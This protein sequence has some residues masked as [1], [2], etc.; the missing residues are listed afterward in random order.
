[1]NAVLSTRN[2]AQL[3]ATF[4]A[5]QNIDGKTI[6]EAISSEC[7]GTL[8]DGFKAIVSFAR[9]PLAFY[10]DR[11]YYSMKGAGTDDDTLIRIVVGR[12]EVDLED[13]KEV[14]YGKYEKSLYEFIDDDCGG[15]YK[16]LLLGICARKS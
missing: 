15:D 16:R 2:Y 11:L 1:L 9:D 8:E 7:S 3:R 6:E 13:I 4:D 10:A 12:S 5:Y 14:F